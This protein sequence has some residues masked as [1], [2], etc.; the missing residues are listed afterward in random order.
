MVTVQELDSF[1]LSAHSPMGPVES[2][3]LYAEAIMLVRLGATK[4][5]KERVKETCRE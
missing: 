5:L 4:S 3:G 1:A 2:C